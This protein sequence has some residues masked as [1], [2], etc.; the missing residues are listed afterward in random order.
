MSVEPQVITFDAS[1]TAG[2]NGLGE[3]TGRRIDPK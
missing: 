1:V 3:Q 2:R